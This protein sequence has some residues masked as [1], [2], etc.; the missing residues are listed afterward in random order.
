MAQIGCRKYTFLKRPYG[1][2]QNV[3]SGPETIIIHNL[4]LPPGMKI[5]DPRLAKAQIISEKRYQ[6][7]AGQIPQISLEPAYYFKAY[8]DII[9]IASPVPNRFDVGYYDGE[10]CRTPEVPAPFFEVRDL[11]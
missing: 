2:C 5:D 3:W 4:Y 8:T 9:P 11:R 1:I 7:K 10:L 6:L